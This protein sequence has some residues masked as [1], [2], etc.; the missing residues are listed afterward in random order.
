MNISKLKKELARV[1]DDN[2]HTKQWHNFF[3]Y[4]IMGFIVVSIIETFIS[5]FTISEGLE[6]ILLI[7][8][9]VVQIFFTIEVSLRI[10]AASEINPKYKGFWG[11]I[12]Y[13]FSFYGIID[14]LATYPFWINY[15]IPMPV[16]ALRT[17][18]IARL[19]Q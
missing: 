9:W 10:W 14:I 15:L 8:D 11:R 12:K 16:S 1:F 4:V 13:C 3:D 7:I 17:F 6:K 2:L 18:R 19:F 5:T